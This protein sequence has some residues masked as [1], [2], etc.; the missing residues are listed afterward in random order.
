MGSF[1]QLLVLVSH[2]L[3]GQ[4]QVQFPANIQ[5]FQDS[6]LVFEGRLARDAAGKFALTSPDYD[7]PAVFEP[8]RVYSQVYV[9]HRPWDPG[10]SPSS[11]PAVAAGTGAAATA[12]AGGSPAAG[13]TTGRTAEVAPAGTPDLAEGR[14]GFEPAWAAGPLVPIVVDL[15]PLLLAA[16][17]RAVGNYTLPW[18][19]HPMDPLLANAN[20]NA[21][22]SDERMA[23]A[24]AM[25]GA[26]T[27]SMNGATAASPNGAASMNGAAAATAGSGSA[28]VQVRVQARALTFILPAHN[29][30]VQVSPTR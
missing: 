7:G 25:P 13:A 19:D 20:A 22:A 27:A 24:A 26:N 28:G 21:N 18:I 23:D 14:A 1:W 12:T 6:R 10:D 9:V 30:V 3:V 2:V 11:A 15:T 16:P 29:Y 5:V 4:T 17:V 8:S